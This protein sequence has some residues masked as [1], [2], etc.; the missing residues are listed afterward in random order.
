MVDLRQLILTCCPGQLFF[1]LPGATNFDLLPGTI[2]A[3]KVLEEGNYSRDYGKRK[4]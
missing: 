3:I 4:E 2:I 1:S